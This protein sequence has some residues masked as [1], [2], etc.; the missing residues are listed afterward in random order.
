MRLSANWAGAKVHL[1]YGLVEWF[2]P[3]IKGG[4]GFCE[5]INFLDDIFNVYVCKY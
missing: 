3:H 2:V 5:K 1:D 4:R